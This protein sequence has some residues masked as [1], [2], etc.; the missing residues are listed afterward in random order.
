MNPTTTRCVRALALAG[1]TSLAS[2]LAQAAPAQEIRATPLRPPSGDGTKMTF[3]LIPAEKSGLVVNNAYDDP[4]MWGD[5]FTEFKDGAIGS[6]IA[7]GDIDGDGLVDIFVANKVRPNQLFKQ[8]SPFV[9][10]DITAAAGVAGDAAANGL[11]WKTGVTMA[12][13]DNDG[14]L[15]IYVCRYNA[16]NLLYRNDG[17]G[18]FTEVARL[19]GVDLVSGSVVGAFADFDRDGH[20]DLFVLTNVLDAATAGDGEPDYLYRNRGDGTFEEVSVAAGLGRERG[21]GHSVVWFDA[22]ED[23]WP[24]LYVANDF[25]VADRFLRNNGDGTFSCMMASSVPYTTWFSMG[26]DAADV[27]NDGRFDL[28][29]ADMAATTHYKAKVA[30][31]D[32]GGLVDDMDA[33][34]TPQYMNNVLFVNSGVDRFLQTA[35]MAGLASSDWTWS[36][37]FEDLDNDGWVDLHLTNGMVRNFINS[38]LLNETRKM[39]S[40]RDII[41]RVKNSPR[42]DETNFTWRNEGD[43]KFKRVQDEW[44]LNQTGVSFGSAFADFDN[45]GDMDLVFVNYDDTVTLL[46]NDSPSGG[47][48]I[49]ALQG[50]Q[51]N[52]HG[53][54]A[55]IFARTAQ[56]VQSRLLTIARG[57]LS[58][59]EPVAHFGLGESKTVAEL[60]VHWPSG[61]VQ[62]FH[63]LAAGF[64]YVISEPAG[65]AQRP[66]AVQQRP[67]DQGLFAD[68]ATARG[69]DYVNQERVFNDMIRQSLLPNRMNTL[70]GGLSWG[71]LNGDGRLDLFFAGPAG[72]GS[73]IYLGSAKGTFQRLNGPQPWEAHRE[74]EAMTALL[75]DVDGD[76]DLDVLLTAGSTEADLPSDLYRSRLYLNDGSA[77]FREAEAKQF[78]LPAFSAAI[79]AAADFDRDGD[80]DVFIGGRVVPGQYPTPPI[81]VFLE[82]R[83]GQLVDRTDE[84]FPSLRQ[85]GMVTAAVWTDV[86]GDGWLDL[87]V[88]GEWMPLR[89]FRNNQNGTFTESTEA[90]GLAGLTGW[91][92]SLLAV[93][94][95]H[96]GAIDFVAGNFGYNTKYKADAQHPVSVY[97]VD[98]EGTGVCEIVE[99]KYEGEKLFPVRGR[100]CSSR[101]M[102]SLAKKFPTFHDW[103]QALLPEIYPEEKLEQ[104]LQVS[105]TE[106]RS[107]VF[108]NDGRGN[109]TFQALPRMAQVAPIF[110]LAASDFDGDGLMDL[111]ALQNFNGPQVETGRYNG[112][113]SLLLRGDGKG[114]FIPVSPLESGIAISGEGRGLT[115]AD[116]DHDGWPDLVLTRTNEQ[117]MALMHKGSR[118]SAPFSVRLVGDRGNE[119][120]IGAR[121]TVRRADGLRQTAEVVSATGHLSQSQ[122]LGFFTRGTGGKAVAIEVRWP[123]GTTTHHRDV[124][125][126]SQLIIRKQDGR[127]AGSP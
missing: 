42:L 66:A 49:V 16:P 80:L 26:S 71:D 115:L 39:Q 124:V 123:D 3:T 36:P 25:S 38:D 41:A 93:D 43:L 21:R 100:S 127:L 107:G 15:D 1:L 24:D 91:W 60:E 82:N 98:F 61:H 31:G 44:G 48:I 33:M 57:A 34:V 47:R 27:N 55:R 74:S 73:A 116:L 86:D 84:L 122:P 113:M 65:I 77:S 53:A 111:V 95:N 114:G 108:L 13:Y 23:G 30:M 90:A 46:R 18:R 79:A 94:V 10:V 32:M 28:F 7:V 63:D 50:R 92:N 12:D 40:Q 83:A 54:D 14:D 125:G 99:A 11:G 110:G 78:S 121:I 5:R 118:E 35:R 56:G 64:R 2:A 17:N 6:G 68:E 45:D 69:L 89:I 51:S 76:G 20:I 29:V 119:S 81:S 87:A 22:N 102:P 52:S 4:A 70:G 67:A 37:R 101:A 96:D 104:S 8:V 85:S 72:H 59:S 62:R 120:A 19:A 97:F 75:F 105:V 58:S 9:F 112:G 109:F 117:V 106:L 88:T 126:Q 103:G